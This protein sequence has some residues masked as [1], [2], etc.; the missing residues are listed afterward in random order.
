MHKLLCLLIPLLLTGCWSND[1]V[2]KFN[3]DNYLRATSVHPIEIPD[4]LASTTYME[5]Y[6]PAPTGKYPDPGQE[7]ISILPPGLGDLI[8]EQE[9]AE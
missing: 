1:S 5:P 9:K 7:P 4:E 6:Y 2:N 3:N 8:P